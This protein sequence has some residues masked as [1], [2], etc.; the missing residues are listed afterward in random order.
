MLGEVQEGRGEEGH[1]D[2]F[3]GLADIGFDL[4]KSQST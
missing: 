1:I 4:K 3:M 2:P